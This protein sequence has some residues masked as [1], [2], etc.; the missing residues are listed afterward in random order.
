MMSKERKERPRRGEEEG[1]GG[2]CNRRHVDAAAGCAE[3]E[4]V[5]K[6]PKRREKSPNSNKTGHTPSN[7]AAVNA[8]VPLVPFITDQGSVCS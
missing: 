2:G 6:P 3:P 1:G 5:E 7:R 4:T 8:S